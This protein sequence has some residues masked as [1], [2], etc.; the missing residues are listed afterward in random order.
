MCECC[1]LFEEG[2]RT[3]GELVEEIHGGRHGEDLYSTRRDVQERC[4]KSVEAETLDDERVLN[5]DTSDEIGEGDEDHENV[6]FRISQGLD[7]PG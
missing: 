5:T 7:E 6:C 4:L 2:K 1:D 3:Y